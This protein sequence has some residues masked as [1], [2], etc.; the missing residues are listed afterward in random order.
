MHFLRC[1]SSF[2]IDLVVMDIR[3]DDE[4]PLLLGGSLLARYNEIID[5]DLGEIILRSNNEH[6]SYNISEVRVMREMFDAT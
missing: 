4:C 2:P 6:A 1:A 3:D 5:F